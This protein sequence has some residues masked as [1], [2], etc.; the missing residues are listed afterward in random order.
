[1]WRTWRLAGL[2]IEIDWVIGT[3]PSNRQH[4]A[5]SLIYHGL[6][7]WSWYCGVFAFVP[8]ILVGLMIYLE[9]EL[10]HSLLDAT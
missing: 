1:M 8:L 10:L 5:G 2:R 9:E 4:K 7:L 6:L 3:G